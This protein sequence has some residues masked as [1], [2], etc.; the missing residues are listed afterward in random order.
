MKIQSEADYENA[1]ARIEVLKYAI[2]SDPEY[3]E[4]VA[5][6]SAAVDYHNEHHRKCADPIDRLINEIHNS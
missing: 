3:A 2:P 1:T 5:L 6:T 4:F